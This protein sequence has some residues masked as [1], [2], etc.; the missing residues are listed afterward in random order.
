MGIIAAPIVTSNA[1]ANGRRRVH[2]RDTLLGWLFIA[3]ATLITLIFG[4]YPV[5]YGFFVSLKGG[6]VAPTGFVGLLNYVKVL[7]GVGYVF[8]IAV[9]LVFLFGA[10]HLWRVVYGAPQTNRRHFAAYLIPALIIAP[11]TLA[12]GALIFLENPAGLIFPIIAILIAI[13]LYAVVASRTPGSPAVGYA[14]RTWGIVLLVLCGLVT[15]PFA[16]Q[17]IAAN[18]ASSFTAL[19]PLFDDV[20][21]Y[22]PTLDLQFGAVGILIGAVLAGWL[23]YLLQL[24]A[25][26]AEQDGLSTLFGVVRLLAFLVGAIAFVFIVARADQLRIAAMSIGQIDPAKLSDALA[27]LGSVATADSLVRDLLTWPQVFA[28]LLG[29]TLIGVAYL[30]WQNAVKRE[31]TPGLLGMFLL[32]IFLIVGGWLLIGELPGA[33]ASGSADFYNSILRTATYAFVTVPLEMGF[34]LVIAYL[35][36]HEITVGK[37]LFRVIYFIPYIAPTVATAAVFS[38]VFSLD[39]AS[40]ANQFMHVL[41]L[42]PQQWLRNPSGIFQIIARIIGG[43]QVQLPPFLVGPSLPLTTAIIFSVWVF[44]GYNAVIFMAGLGGVPRELYEA[45]EVDGASRWENFRYITLPM[46]SPTTFFLAVLAIIG[47]FQALTHIYV[48]RTP[49]SRGSM[50][51]ATVLIFDSIRNGLL[52]YAS[53]MAFVLFAIILVL[54]LVQNRVAKDQVFYG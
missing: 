29:T 38:V 12:I 30:T 23:L 50:D 5:I 32:A 51:V 27:T 52:P 44:S 9:G 42:P 48:L 13:V 6:Q 11:A 17:Q 3:P 20:G 18:T 39:R 46:I 34:G 49:A 8:A 16:F 33:V 36:F 26:K 21:V 24:N 22:L 25:R 14:L 15:I 45:A 43:S 28:V 35:L 2:W 41:G 4:L 7:G 10:Y 54:T 40:P 1:I 47:T 19:Q 31:S 53:A 37:S